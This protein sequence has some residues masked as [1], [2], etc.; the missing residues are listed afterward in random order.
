MLTSPSRP[1]SNSVTTSTTLALAWSS[2]STKPWV[3]EATTLMTRRWTV[4]K[5]MSNMEWMVACSRRWCS[6]SRCSWWCSTRPWMDLRLWDTTRSTTQE[7]T[8]DLSGEISTLTREMNLIRRRKVML[9]SKTLLT[10]L[11]AIRR[12]ERVPLSTQTSFPELRSSTWRVF[13]LLTRSALTATFTKIQSQ[14]VTSMRF[15][16]TANVHQVS[17][18]LNVWIRLPSWIRLRRSVSSR[19]TCSSSRC[20]S[21]R[22]S[23]FI[24]SRRSSNSTIIRSQTVELMTMNPLQLRLLMEVLT[25]T[26]AQTSGT[27]SLTLYGLNMM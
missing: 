9:L 7:L 17:T 8:R 4:L 19:C 14:W 16:G 25:I 1:T 3:W 11:L 26:P 23:R 24:Q 5:T 10:T 6:S 21:R 27:S 20:S 13:V 2:K 15:R 18:H 22:T 12:L